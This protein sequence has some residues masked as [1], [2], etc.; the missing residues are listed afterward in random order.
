MNASDVNG[1]LVQM[2]AAAALAQG[3]SR[4]PVPTT[5]GVPQDFASLLRQSID[6][7]SELQTHAG[8]LSNSFERGAPGIDLPDVMIATQK[9][10]IS[11]QALTQVRN[12][13]VTAYQ[14]IMSM[15]V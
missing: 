14:D 7:V 15:Q 13:F 4:V 8:D 3:Q 9:A 11:F 6:S 2:R 12:K 1:L 5:E 10:N